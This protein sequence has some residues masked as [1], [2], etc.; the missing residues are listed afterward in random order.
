MSFKKLFLEIHPY[1]AETSIGALDYACSLAS[2]FGAKLEVSSSRLTVKKTSHWLV[3]SMVAGMAGEIEE[4]A[5][6]SSEAMEAALTERAKS[7]NIKIRIAQSRRQWPATFAENVWRGR[8]CDLCVLP[9][10]NDAEQRTLVEDWLFQAGRPCLIY[11][12]ALS[13]GFSLETMVISWDLSRSAARAVGDALPLLMK[14]KSVHVVTVRGEKDL[15]CADV[16][17][18]LIEYLGEHGVRCSAAD[19]E[20]EGATI[21]RA[22]LDYSAKSNADLLVMGAYGHSRAREFFL[23]GATKSALD[24]GSMPLF[25]AH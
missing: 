20:L 25:M 7:L 21:G 18:P 14:A 3:G 23:G 10:Q 13:K 15:P 5:S 17:A 1:P 9:M 6:A 12:D 19:I 22:I 24:Y 4:R 2:A 16:A 11:P 8:T